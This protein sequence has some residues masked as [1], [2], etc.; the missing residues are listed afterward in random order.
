MLLAYDTFAAIPHHADALDVGAVADDHRFVSLR[1]C[2][3]FYLVSRY[4]DGAP[5]AEDLRA[6]AHSGEASERDIERARALADYLADLHAEPVDNPI[7]YR[8]AIRDLIG[9]GEGIFGIVDGYPDDTEPQLLER[10][11][12]IERRAAE[13]RWKLRGRERRCRRTHGD[14]HPFNVLFTPAGEIALLDAARGCLGDPA[15]D[16]VCM[17]INYPFFAIASPGS[18]AGAFEKLWTSYWDRYLQRAG[19]RELLEVGPPFMAWRL[20]VV[21]NPRWYP[22]MGD[23][24][25]GKLLAVAEAAL[26]RGEVPL[27]L[28]GLID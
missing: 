20:L 23:E 19:D 12:D 1:G 10:I 26:D 21:A 9:H 24:Q 16:V 4:C 17:A 28:E 8:R 6:I 5:Y 27:D 14:F 11:R 13:W 22:A 3:E 25:R 18:W 7:G 15:D 2:G